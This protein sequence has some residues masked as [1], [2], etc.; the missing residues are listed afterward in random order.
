MGCLRWAAAAA[1]V[2]GVEALLAFVLVAV[3]VA[4]LLDVVLAAASLPLPFDDADAGGGAAFL[5]AG[6]S[7]ISTLE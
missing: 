3:L 4:L 7:G 6:H 1:F 5:H 2:D